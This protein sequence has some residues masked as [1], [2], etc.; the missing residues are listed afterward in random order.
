MSMCNNEYV[1]ICIDKDFFFLEYEISNE[2]EIHAMPSQMNQIPITH[3]T[4]I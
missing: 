4:E 3:G 1:Y 2:M